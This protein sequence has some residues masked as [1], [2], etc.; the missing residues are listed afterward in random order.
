MHNGAAVFKI[1]FSHLV[2]QLLPHAYDSVLFPNR[3][4]SFTF[5]C[6]TLICI[7]PIPSLQPFCR[8]SFS[9]G[10]GSWLWFSV[11]ADTVPQLPN[12]R[13][14][15]GPVW[16]SNLGSQFLLFC[17]Y[18]TLTQTKIYLYYIDYKVGLY[19]KENYKILIVFKFFH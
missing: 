17:S 15:W 7:F 12:S 11:P 18:S 2:Y 8:N 9:E 5:Q 1:C 16:L 3:S 6:F 4:S 13:F 10:Q 19:L 14:S